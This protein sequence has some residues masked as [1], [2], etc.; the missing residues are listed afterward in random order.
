MRIPSHSL[1]RLVF[2]GG[3][4][5]LSLGPVSGAEP[6]I[7]GRQLE[8]DDRAGRLRYLGDVRLD[9]ED[10]VLQADQMDWQRET[11]EVTAA[12]HFVITRGPR[13]LLAESGRYN[14]RTKGMALTGL[15]MGQFPFYVTGATAEGTIDEFRI[16]DAHVLLREDAV[17]APAF[18]AATLTY[19][20]G[21]VL[22]GE[23][24]RLGLLG[25]R[26]I[27][28][29]KLDQ[30]L[31]ADYLSYAS[32][33]L[34]YRSNLGLIAEAG[35]HL[36]V[37]GGW[38]L[39]GDVTA[40]SRRGVMAGPSG[41]YS[42]RGEGGAMTGSFS[43]G[44][45]SDH[46]D[47]RADIL[48]EPIGRERGLVEWR[49]RQAIGDAIT[50]EGQF[51][52][53][54]DSEVVRDFRPRYYNRDQQPDS[55]LEVSWREADWQ[56]AAFARAHPNSFHRSVE[57]WPELRADLLPSALGGGLYQRFS[58]SV[59]RLEEDAQPAG[60]GRRTD[61]LDAYYGIEYPVRLAPW[62]GLTPVAGGRWTHYSRTIPTGESLDR[63]IGEVGF[64]AQALVSGTWDYRNAAW[65][66]DGLRHLVEPGLSYRY[67]PA[68]DHGRLVLPRL[69]R[70][71][72]ASYLQP[73]SIADSRNVDDLQR[74]DTLRVQLR[75]VLQTRDA[76]YGS[77]DLA[78]FTVA[79][80]HWFTRPE[81][82]SG[83]KGWSDLHAELAL[84]PAPW[85]QL[86][87]YHRFDPRDSTLREFDLGL[88]VTDQEWWSVRLAQL[89]LR[90]DYHEYLVDARLRLN[91]TWDAAAKWR[92]DARRSRFNEQTY[93]LWQKLGQTWAVKY[94]VSLFDGPRRESAFGFN[95]EVEL[96]KF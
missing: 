29:P 14:L 54:S 79:A 10:L 4:I 20:K 86:E 23:D 70:R 41:R 3:L 34:G 74:L 15:R 92:Y 59:A 18:S 9:Y 61:R 88:T 63:S 30:D 24:I 93:G 96:M 36:P 27:R 50:I 17:Y 82:G 60:P 73:L 80:D 67:A 28:L 6:V 95:V 47:R 33:R 48:G 32:G 31:Q 40:F 43:S 25:S 66:V 21:R 42:R 12:G 13:R 90:D 1:F 69:D 49:H 64:D 8:Y 35:L 57:R 52:Y 85:I 53:W 78:E 11:G 62:L 77:R 91:E 58:A 44:F 71:V 16:T 22:A 37:A 89:Y 87:L 5:A 55:F 65:G 39:G 7:R 2:V 51:N 81:N 75:N 56:L 46:G 83:R 19:A 94:E 72:L 26:F 76:A 68:A 84:K 38:S 45:I